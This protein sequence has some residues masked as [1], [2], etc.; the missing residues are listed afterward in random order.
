[1]TNRAVKDKIGDSL[2]PRN[3]PVCGNDKIRNERVTLTPYKAEMTDCTRSNRNAPCAVFNTPRNDM[4]GRPGVAVMFWKPKLK[5][6]SAAATTA[7]SRDRCQ[8]GH[9]GRCAEL[10]AAGGDA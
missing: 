5:G 3:S 10:A 6:L 8:W 7:V 4:M 9:D 2:S 1:M